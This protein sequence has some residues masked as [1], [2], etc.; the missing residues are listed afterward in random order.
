M[1]RTQKEKSA[2]KILN[3]LLTYLI[4]FFSIFALCYSAKR[5]IDYVSLKKETLK[6][7]N[8]MFQF[9]V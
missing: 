5:I 4:L 3:R 1:E 2:M 8:H 9:Q 7:Y 6:C